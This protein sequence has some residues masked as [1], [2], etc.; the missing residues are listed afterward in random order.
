MADGN[1][2][3]VAETIEVGIPEKIYDAF[4]D[5]NGVWK[6]SFY[7]ILRGGRGGGKSETFARFGIGY[8]R[9]NRG[10]VLCGRQY[11]NSIKDSIHQT[12]I[13][14]AEDMRVH[15]EFKITDRTLVHR[16]SGTDFLYK[17]FQRDIAS[18]KSTK[19]L[20]RAIVD[21]ANS[22][23]KHAWQVLEPTMRGSD[24]AEIWAAYNPEQEEEPI[25]QMGVIHPRPDAI[26]VE[27][28]HR[29][30]PYFPEILERQRLACLE[31]DPDAYDWIWEGKTR[32]IS[33]AQVFRNRWSCETFDEPED[34]QPLYGLDFGF[35][36]DPTFGTRSF[37]HD[38]CLYITDEAAGLHVEN[39]DIR[40]LLLGTL[41]KGQCLPGVQDWPIKADCSRPETI[42]YL[43]RKGLPN[44]SGAEKWP[45]SVE[46]G[47][48]HLKAYRHIFI[49]PRC[50]QLYQ[51]FRLYSYKVDK[52]LLDAHGNPAILPIILDKW[53]HGIDSLR[54]ALDGR[55][56]GKGSMRIS[57]EA[58]NKIR[59]RR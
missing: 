2:P 7:K 1:P 34:V 51:E 8:A 3:F 6:P 39:D 18:I 49:H 42:S 30:N 22:V 54:Y 17:G 45:G 24:D 37:E 58:K 5:E 53:N 59:S 38:D 32:K 36:N 46:D 26:V 4:I 16:T 31:R 55:I 25:H 14:V 9:S 29:D 43:R 11:M 27:V 57:P 44:I 15:N 23:T 50:V 33:D 28:N 40:R 13:D 10:R 35:A 20:T 41:I 48:S 19:G 47:V 52:L 12:L 21:E 56:K